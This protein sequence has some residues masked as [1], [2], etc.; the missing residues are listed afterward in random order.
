MNRLKPFE[1]VY[2]GTPYTRYPKG[3]EMAFIDACKLTARLLKEGIKVYSP[4]AHTHP[5]AIHGKIDPL[6][7]NTWL[8]FDAAIMAKAD[9]MIVAQMESWDRSTGVAHEIAV[10]KAAGKPIFYLDPEDLR[11]DVSP[12][13]RVA[14]PLTE[15]PD[16]TPTRA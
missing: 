8:P 2:V 5:V 10:F 13:L 7:L 14:I 3:I 11:I 9:A 6:D 1:L 15:Q 16:D 4:I 12:L